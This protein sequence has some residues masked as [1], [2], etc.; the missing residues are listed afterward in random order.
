MAE[1]SFPVPMPNSPLFLKH[2]CLGARFL[3]E[4]RSTTEGFFSRSLAKMC[5]VAMTAG[6]LTLKKSK[7]VNAFPKSPLVYTNV[8][9]RRW[10]AHL[11]ESRF[12]P[13]KAS[14]IFNCFHLQ[15]SF[16]DFYNVFCF[17]K[18]ERKSQKQTAI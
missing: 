16:S 5:A 10:K 4:P 9:S 13:A 2:L 17:V 7:P 14:F 15:L 3:Q 1:N 8:Q 11:S 18:R 6:L 12:K